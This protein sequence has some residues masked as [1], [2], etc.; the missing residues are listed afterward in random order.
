MRARAAI[1]PGIFFRI[2]SGHEAAPP[3]TSVM[4]SRLRMT[5]L[6][7]SEPDILVAQTRFSKE[8]GP[9]VRYMFWDNG[10]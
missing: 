10:H 4:K 5:A 8:A 7:G 9:V 2:V 6:E 3:P 1:R